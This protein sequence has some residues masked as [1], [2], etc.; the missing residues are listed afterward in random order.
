V[1]KLHIQPRGVHVGLVIA[2]GVAI[3]ATAIVAW[4]ARRGKLYAALSIIDPSYAMAV[5]VQ[6]RPTCVGA[7]LEREPKKEEGEGE[8]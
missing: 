4:S 7:S 8:G 5:R 6:I 3:V 1:H 2:D